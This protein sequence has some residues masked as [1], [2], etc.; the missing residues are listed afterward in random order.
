M[1]FSQTAGSMSS[2]FP[3]KPQVEDA[4][5]PDFAV[6]SNWSKDVVL[7]RPSSEIIGADIER[8]RSW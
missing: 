3:D 4:Q 5:P 8:L 7:V 1:I 2:G 6:A